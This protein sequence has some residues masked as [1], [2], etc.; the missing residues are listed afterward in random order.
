MQRI[1]V[2]IIGA[3]PI[4]LEVGYWLQDAGISSLNVDAGEIGHTIA[5]LFPPSTRF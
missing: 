4:G 3:G 1:N 5:R 2:L